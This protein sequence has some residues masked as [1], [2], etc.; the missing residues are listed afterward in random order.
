VISVRGQD[1]FLYHPLVVQ[2]AAA[3]TVPSNTVPRPS[4]VPTFFAMTS[5]CYTF[6]SSEPVM[7]FYC[8]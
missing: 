7:T 3:G 5:V 1:L 4:I 6:Y 8:L 2:H